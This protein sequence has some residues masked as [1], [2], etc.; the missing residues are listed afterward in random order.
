MENNV[1][2]LFVYGDSI[3]LQYGFKLKE[4]LD[5]LN[6]NY[7]RL[8]SSNSNDL[9]SP[10]YNGFSTRE[11]IIWIKDL[12]IQENTLL[13]FNCGL[14]DIVHIEIDQECQVEILEY[15]KNLEFIIESSTKK[16]TNVV[17]CNTTPVE[18]KRHNSNTNVRFRYNADVEAYNEVAQEVMN[19]RNVSIIDLYEIT[20]NYSKDENIYIDHI[21]FN[22]KISH[23]HAQKI[24][25]ELI[26][27]D[28]IH[29]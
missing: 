16:F 24:I 21:H 11:M 25:E 10:I 20:M 1:E 27:S 9:A 23:L 8:G 6:I 14:H 15:K 28:Y 19:K 22:K 4:K 17:F 2:K 29:G 5:S 7:N 12:P 18:D 26:E 3:S 13:L